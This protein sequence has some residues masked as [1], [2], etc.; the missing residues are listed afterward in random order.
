[1]FR[2]FHAIVK[3]FCSNDSQLW[4]ARCVIVLLGIRMLHIW[5]IPALAILAV[6]LL[7][8]YLLVKLKGG[9]GVRSEGRTLMDRPEAE[10]DLPPQ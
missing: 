9:S 5:L 7:A 6:L 2:I 4:P 10:E 1:M 3:L 8:F